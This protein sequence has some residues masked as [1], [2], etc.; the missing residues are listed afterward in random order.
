[1][2]QTATAESLTWNSIFSQR[3]KTGIWRQ[4]CFDLF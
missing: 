2:V 4:N 3:R 1:M